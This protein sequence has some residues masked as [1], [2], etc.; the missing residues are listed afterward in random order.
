[1]LIVE[2]LVGNFKYS[3][4]YWKKLGIYNF[5]SGK[6]IDEQTKSGSIFIIFI[7]NSIIYGYRI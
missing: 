6:Y 4:F 5:P 3:K 1:M 2:N 7:S